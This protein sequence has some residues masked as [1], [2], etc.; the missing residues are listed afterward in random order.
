M[1]VSTGLHEICLD[2]FSAMRRSPADLIFD[3]NSRRASGSRCVF[4]RIVEESF[5]ESNLASTPRLAWLITLPLQS[6]RTSC[7]ARCWQLLENRL[8]RGC[9]AMKVAAV[10]SS[11]RPRL[12]L[13]QGLGRDSALG[14]PYLPRSRI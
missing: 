3:L 5:V 4:M 7:S 13:L 9:L 12:L 10:Q 2:P 11:Q 1:L 14:N 6:S 8:Y